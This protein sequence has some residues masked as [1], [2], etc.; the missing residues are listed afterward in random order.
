[1]TRHTDKRDRTVGRQHGNLI[2]PYSGL[3]REH[4]FGMGL[5]CCLLILAAISAAAYGQPGLLLN[6]SFQIATEKE[7]KS[8]SPPFV[9]PPEMDGS[10][11]DPC[12]AFC[13]PV[14]IGSDMP[15]GRV[16]RKTTVRIC[17]DAENLFIAFQCHE[18]AMDIIPLV[19]GPPHDVWQK[20]NI[21]IYVAPAREDKD[22]Y[23]FA[24]DPS[25]ARYES[26]L[27]GG[28]GWSPEWNAVVQRGEDNEGTPI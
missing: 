9:E 18:P 27:R 12:W 15:G 21:Q 19:E 25:G 20:E 28:R 3:L 1:M 17:R 10:L 16:S 7:I 6:T 26:S 23:V 22:F 8:V 14:E 24:V 2:L 13:T 11:K 4:A 5:F